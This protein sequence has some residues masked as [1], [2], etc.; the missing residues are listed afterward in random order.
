M[1]FTDVPVVVNEEVSVAMVCVMRSSLT[2]EI[3][4][5]TIITTTT[6]SASGEFDSNNVCDYSSLCRSITLLVHSILLTVN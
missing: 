5:V 1:E 3:M 2:E 4:T 6:G